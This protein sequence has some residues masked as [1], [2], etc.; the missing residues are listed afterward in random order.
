MTAQRHLKTLWGCRNCGLFPSTKLRCGMTSAA[1]NLPDLGARGCQR[2]G[3][4]HAKYRHLTITGPPPIGGALGNV[5]G[6]EL[7]RRQQRQVHLLLYLTVHGG[8]ARCF[9]FTCVL[10]AFTAPGLTM[11]GQHSGSPLSR[12][13]RW[14][15]PTLKGLP[16][17]PKP[18][19][20][21]SVGSSSRYS[22]PTSSRVFAF[23][24]Q[25]AKRRG[26]ST[27]SPLRQLRGLDW[28]LRLVGLEVRSAR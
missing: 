3:N 22:T 9:G 20:Q 7:L 26:R 25:V 1:S 17:A 12:L 6:L 28:L 23:C 15:P 27:K 16:R 8:A 24:A 5:W 18:R 2:L 10:I 13:V 19:S 11:N 4:G 21:L 14:T